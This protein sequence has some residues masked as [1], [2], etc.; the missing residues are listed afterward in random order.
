MRRGAAFVLLPL[1]IATAS[2]GAKTGLLVPDSGPD[3][4]VDAAL[5]DASMPGRCAIDDPVDVLFVIDNSQSMEEEQESLAAEMP[6]LVE[7]LVR[8]PDIDGDGVPDWNPIANLHMGVVTTDLGAGGAPIGSCERRRGDDAVLRNVGNPRD[9]S[10][11]R[12]FPRFLTYAGSADE[13]DRFVD[14]LACI[15]AVGDTGCGLEQPLE[16]ALKALTPATSALRFEGDTVGHGDGINAGFLRDGSFLAIVIVSDEDD[17]STHDTELFQP[18][19]ERYPEH[20]NLRCYLYEDEALYPIDR[21]LDGIAALRRGPL[22]RLALAVIAGVPVDLVSDED[23]LYTR[24]LDDPRMVYTV[25]PDDDT[26][27]VPSCDVPDRGVANPPRRLVRAARALAPNAT[28]QSICQADLRPATGALV[29]LIGLR[30]C[31]GD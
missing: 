5:P 15:I 13:E 9:F 21:F 11:L 18:E 2:C 7:A 16:A 28:V 30:T 10:C 26:S 24:I 25:D 31:E 1:A 3:G 8:P 19:S 12:R 17:C 23:P 6:R 20:P 22:D 4:G 27:L 14:D 29:R